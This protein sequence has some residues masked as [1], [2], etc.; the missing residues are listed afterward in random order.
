MRALLI[1]RSLRNRGADFA[2]PDSEAAALVTVVS[3]SSMLYP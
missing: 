2:A 3:V 1:A